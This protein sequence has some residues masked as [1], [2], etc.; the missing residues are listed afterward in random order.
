MPSSRDLKIMLVL[1]VMFMALGLS[2]EYG[3][4][5]ADV[6]LISPL[7]CLAV[8]LLAGRYVGEEQLARLA[9]AVASRRR[10]RRI[11]AAAPLPRRAPVRVVRGG[12]ILGTAL[13]V[14]PPPAL[15][16]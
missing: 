13:A 3:G 16:V 7:L 1:G 8:P 4:V 9:A 5:H 14:R 6:L 12:L 10:P 11:A 15:S 2:V